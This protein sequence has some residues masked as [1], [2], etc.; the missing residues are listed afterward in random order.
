MMFM[1]KKNGYEPYFVPREEELVA[2]TVQLKSMHATFNKRQVY[3]VDG[4]RLGAAE[5]VEVAI[6]E[7]AGPFKSDDKLKVT[8]DNSKGMLALLA[9]LKTIADMYKYALI[10]EFKRFKL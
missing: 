8:F 4:V 10:D 5:D 7:T 9:M 2:M 3:R 6:L 1:V